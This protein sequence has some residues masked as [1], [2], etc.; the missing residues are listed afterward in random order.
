MASAVL[1]SAVRQKLHIGGCNYAAVVA[2]P[3]DFEIL[4]ATAANVVGVSASD[5]R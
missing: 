4:L 1:M 5:R 2:K 3:F